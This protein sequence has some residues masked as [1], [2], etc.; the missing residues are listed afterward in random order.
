M[1]PHLAALTWAQV[2]EDAYR[3]LLPVLTVLAGLLAAWLTQKYGGKA[4][5]QTRSELQKQLQQHA[6]DAVATVYQRTV[7]PLKDT[8]RPGEFGE[9]EKEQAKQAAWPRIEPAAGP[10]LDSRASSG[11]RASRIGQAIERAVVELGTKTPAG[12]DPRATTRVEVVAAEAKKPADVEAA[13]KQS[14]SE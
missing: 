12:T 10:S 11:N 4:D 3:I 2:A 5:A 6:L 13:T 7:K 14:P 8:H 9:A 1:N